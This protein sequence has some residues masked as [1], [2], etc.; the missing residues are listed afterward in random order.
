MVAVVTL[1]AVVT[2]SVVTGGCCH[3]G[4]CGDGGGIGGGWWW[5]LS[6]SL[7]QWLSLLGAVVAESTEGQWWLQ[8]V[9]NG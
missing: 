3:C 9:E 4:Y 1:V 2:D 7:W 8:Y 6:P 5:L